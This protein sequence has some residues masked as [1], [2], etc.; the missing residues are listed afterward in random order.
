MSHRLK[1]MYFPRKKF[2]DNI[3]LWY[4]LIPMNLPAD[5]GGFR[6]NFTVE[7][8]LT[9][10]K[11]GLVLVSFDDNTKEWGALGGL[12]LTP[13]AIYYEPHI[14]SR[15]VQGGRTRSGEQVT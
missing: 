14:N 9:C 6:K 12:V 10:P 3:C 4:G 15:I 2:W 1:G 8:T 5:C 11:E 7:H 13:S